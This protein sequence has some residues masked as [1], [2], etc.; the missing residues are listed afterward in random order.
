[1]WQDLRPNYDAENEQQPKSQ[2]STYPSFTNFFKKVI[3]FN[4]YG[5][6]AYMNVNIP[7]AFPNV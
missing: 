1:M 5:C 3:S 2:T 7:Y 4:L 6:F